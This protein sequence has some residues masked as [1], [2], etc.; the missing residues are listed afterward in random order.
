MT[1]AVTTDLLH[2]LVSASHA[3]GITALGVQAVITRDTS[4]LFLAEDGGDFIDDSW[5]L[6]SGTVL[7][8][9]T[10]TDALYPAMAVIGLHVDEVTG[11][12]GHD[13]DGGDPVVRTFRFTVTVTVTDAICRSSRRSHWWADIDVGL[14][15]VAGQ[16][17][18][19]R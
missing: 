2:Q 6:P 14:S 8:G 4:V 15:T 18:R 12:L 13:D 3:E 9:Q 1:T 17:P 7:P 16:A 11:Y 5:Q 19:Q 10:L